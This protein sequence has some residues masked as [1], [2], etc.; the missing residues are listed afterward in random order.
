MSQFWLALTFVCSAGVFIAGEML[1]QKRKQQIRRKH[2]GSDLVHSLLSNALPGAIVQGAAFFLLSN[3]SL[4]GARAS[5]PLWA[6]VLVM[7]LITEFTF[8][9]VH[10]LMHTHPLLWKI[11]RLHHSI[12]EMDWLSGYRKHILETVVQTM[13][14][15]LPLAALGFSP[16]AWLI[17][18]AIGILATGY[19]HWNIVTKHDWLSHLI[20]TPEYHA[21]HHQRQL[22]NQQVNFAGKLS[23]FDKL[24]GTD[25]ERHTTSGPLGLEEPS[26][27]GFWS[28][29]R[30][31]Q[32]STRNSSLKSSFSKLYQCVVFALKLPLVLSRQVIHNAWGILNV[33]DLIALRPM[34]K[35]LISDSH[36]FVSGLSPATGQEIWTNNVV[37][38][39]PR[40]AGLVNFAGN[41]L[42][43]DPEIISTIGRF[44][45]KMVSFSARGKGEKKAPR[46]P[47]AINYLHGAVHYNAGWF[48][49]ND[50]KEAY[51]TFSDARFRNDFK[52]FVRNEKREP[53][54]VF[55]DLHFSAKEYGNFVCFLRSH[56]HWF[57]NSNAPKKKVLWGN[58][59]PFATVNV[60]T[61]RW[62]R[63][64]RALKGSTS[65]TALLP[66]IQKS[67][68]QRD[69]QGWREHALWPERL[70]RALTQRR[71]AA[72]GKRGNLF[73][74]D[75]RKLNKP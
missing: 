71:I 49:F 35:R 13:V 38:S 4:H 30:L 22:A 36:P 53:L 57:A 59:A 46:M 63:Y 21:V 29:Q 44:M 55:R 58:P 2:L 3:L 65:R 10:R 50:F 32:T 40:K 9:W 7:L 69:Y 66:A 23:L 48:I 52:R 26:A 70:L 51:K 17:F 33:L 60:I 16:N 56:F 28:Q 54:I 61:G 39:T 20:V 12:R 72:R 25:A 11:H 8:Y 43:S 73:F 45:A 6:E 5:W 19:T 37:F 75:Q 24:F 27:S 74:V 15:A 62:I 42:K 41:P 34:Q 31:P 67:Y 68:F 14:P 18:G 1:R 64:V 47:P